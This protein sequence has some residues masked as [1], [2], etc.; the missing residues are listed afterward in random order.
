VNTVHGAIALEGECVGIELTS[1]LPVDKAVQRPLW[2]RSPAVNPSWLEL[3]PS[4][5]AIAVVSL[6]LDPNPVYWNAVFAL[7]DSIEKTVPE[8]TELA[9]IR[10]RLNLLATGAGARLEADLWPHLKGVTAEILGD[11]K[12]PGRPTGGLIALH[13]DSDE[14][15]SRL[16]SQT[17]PR[18][19]KLLDRGL[20]FRFWKSGSSAIVSWGAGVSTAAKAAAANAALSVAALSTNWQKAGKAAPQ[21]LGMFWPA[22]CWPIGPDPKTES[23]AWAALAD[24]P[25]A[26]W[27][28]WNRENSAI[29]SVR[30]PSLEQRVQKFLEQLELVQAAGR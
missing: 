19:A 22:R 30:W 13:L 24:D 27:W 15:A 20:E 26:V 10:T 8:R 11:S 4:D 23:T 7:A 1:Q 25:P 16:V 18:V 5:G 14:A 28:G 21:R 2:V 12:Q 3:I 17:L 29:D 6:A 9:P